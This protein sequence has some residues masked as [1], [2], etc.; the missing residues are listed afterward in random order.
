MIL[1]SASI[2]PTAVKLLWVKCV[3]TSLQYR[4]NKFNNFKIIKNWDYNLAL[5]ISLQICIGTRTP[6]IYLWNSCISF[7][8]STKLRHFLNFALTLKLFVDPSTGD[9][10]CNADLRATF[11][12]QYI[13]SANF[14]NNYPN[15]INCKT[16]ITSLEGTVIELFFHAFSL[17]DSTDCEKDALVVRF[18]A[19]KD[20]FT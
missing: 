9:V 8:L 6:F 13:R 2:I 14:P 18:P 19:P 5:P 3:V 20:L 11:S 7:I 12:P 10:N 15:D 1:F 16:H 4:S 17:E